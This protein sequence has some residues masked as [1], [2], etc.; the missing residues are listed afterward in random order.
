MGCLWWVC[1]TTSRTVMWDL[2]QRWLQCDLASHTPSAPTLPRV[3]RQSA[4]ARPLHVR[5]TFLGLNTINSGERGR[6]INTIALSTV[7]FSWGQPAVMNSCI[8][9]LPLQRAPKSRSQN[10]PGVIQSDDCDHGL[11]AACSD[12]LKQLRECCSRVRLVAHKVHPCVCRVVVVRCH[13]V[14]LAPMRL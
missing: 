7:P 9:F 1:R 2:D 13:A 11:N 8:M 5:E 3:S 10:S 6:Y 14:T 4:A 12:V